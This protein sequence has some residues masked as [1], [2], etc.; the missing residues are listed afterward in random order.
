MGVLQRTFAEKAPHQ[1]LRSVAEVAVVFSDRSLAYLRPH[2]T[3]A[4]RTEDGI[5][6]S[7]MVWQ[8]LALRRLGAPF[9]AYLADDF[10][11]PALPHYK[12][13]LFMDTFYLTEEERAA[14]R[15][16]L[17]EDNA[18]ALWFYTPGAISEE[19]I[20]AQKIAE[21]TGIPVA[22]DFNTRETAGMVDAESG[23]PMDMP[24]QYSFLPAVTP[25]VDEETIVLALKS[26]GRTPAVV[27][28][29]RNCFSAFAGLTPEFL[30]KIA[31]EAGVFIYSE[32]DDAIYANASYLAVHTS[33]R[34]G[35]RTI[36]LPPGVR[37]VRLAPISLHV[38][39][40]VLDEVKFNSE[41]AQTRIYSLVREE[42]PA[43][44]PSSVEPDFPG[45]V[46]LP[47][48]VKLEMR[49]VKAGT[50]RMGIPAGGTVGQSQDG[51]HQV[52]LTR[53]Y[54]L[55]ACEVTQAQWEAVM[56]DNPSSFKLGGEY[57]VENV[58]WHEAKAFCEELNAN[59]DIPRPEGYRFDL[60]TE[61]QWEYA[62]RAGTDTPFSFGEALNGGEANCN[63]KKPYGTT[64]KGPSL[65]ATAPVRQY[66]PNEWG[67][68]DM[69]GNVREWCRDWVLAQTAF[70]F[71]D[72]SDPLQ[73]LTETSRATRGGSW[74]DD[75]GWC[76]SAVRGADFP[77]SRYRTLGFRL[78]LV[79]AQ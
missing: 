40:K 26:D 21:L 13:Y 9:D 56:G 33:K 79:P 75:A 64:E 24:Q 32:D 45:A 43:T 69:H 68:F 30:R 31:R 39:G 16:R 23:K 28:K 19:G 17:A 61:A 51:L 38:D 22:L 12:L 53:D 15:K 18:T 1:D 66:P 72:C 29:G 27:R 74:M 42:Q 5:M 25:M 77:N 52:T 50:F 20:D 36:R 41:E 14:I 78:A 34:P 48:G 70:P 62:C 54:W 37:A 71:A 10:L 60:P 63:G 47:G 2:A 4:P 3:N 57:P 76:R 73:V 7:L 59:P 8:R 65:G 35:P 46:L 11:N 44:A 58:T 6:E 55:G 67:F 49:R